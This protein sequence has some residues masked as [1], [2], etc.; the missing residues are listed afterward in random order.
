MNY[1]KNY[2]FLNANGQVK[3]IKFHQIFEKA[4][5]IIKPIRQFKHTETTSKSLLFINFIYIVYCILIMCILDYWG[6][7]Y[8]VLI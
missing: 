7:K 4:T 5:I 8:K 2:Q 3:T 1:Y 6:H